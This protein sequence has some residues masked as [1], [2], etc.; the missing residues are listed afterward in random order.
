MV[1]WKNLQRFQVQLTEQIISGELPV[2]SEC[3]SSQFPSI[4][5][6]VQQLSGAPGTPVAT[7]VFMR[8]YGLFIAA[9]LYLKAHNKVWDGPLHDIRLTE[10]DGSITFAVNSRYIREAHEDDLK[11]ILNNFCHPVVEALA[12]KGN[13]AKLILWENIW[14]YVLWMYHSL[15]ADKE[16][17]TVDLQ[18]L[19]ADSVWQPKMAS[20]PFCKFLNGRTFTEAATQYQRITCCLYK[21]LP[22]AGN[23]PYCPLSKE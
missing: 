8:R 3:L 2:L 4:I 22:A 14:G 20:S 7:S 17:G 15:A 5:K 11:F 18:L 16:Q 23:C 1:E 12:A 9:Q 6:H 19:L 21:D 13:I 10:A